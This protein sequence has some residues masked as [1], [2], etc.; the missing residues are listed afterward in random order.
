M[1]DLKLTPSSHKCNSISSHIGYQSRNFRD[2]DSPSNETIKATVPSAVS[3]SSSSSSSPSFCTPY[4]IKDILS[5]PVTQSKSVNNA[6]T[7]STFNESDFTLSLPK[8]AS[9]EPM[10]SEPT[11]YFGTSAGLQ[12]NSAMDIS[13]KPLFW[14]NMVQNPAFRRDRLPG[15]DGME[16]PRLPAVKCQLRRHKSN[17]KPRTPFTTQQLLALER[18]F[19]TKQ[20]LSIAERAEFSSSLSLTETQVKIWFQNRRAKEKRL[21]EA[22][23]EKLR[24][25]SRPMLPAFGFHG[26][27]T[28]SYFGFNGPATQ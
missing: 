9:N 8:F 1:D 26:L 2:S 19:R 25:A 20:Y 17:R 6:F 27:H 11:V 22:E 14:Q 16:T 21:K 13:G 3:P 24:I 7:S 5:R 28:A 15:S 23:L 4:S 18:K 10:V 12:L